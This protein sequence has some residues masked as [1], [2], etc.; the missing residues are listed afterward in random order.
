[1]T[2]DDNVYSLNKLLQ[3]IRD[4]FAQII[5]LLAIIGITVGLLFQY[6]LNDIHS[7]QLAFSIVALGGGAPL[8]LVLFMRLLKGRFGSDLLAGISIITSLILGEYLAGALV[9]LMLSGGESLE[10]LALTNASS[11][12]K[13]LA[14]RLPIYAHRKTE[15][16]YT[17]IEANEIKV[18]D[19]LLLFP[20][21]TCPVDGIVVSGHS[22]MDESY[23]TGEPYLISKTLGSEVISGSLNGE[24][25]LTI[26]ATRTPNTS[27]YAQ[28]VDVM[29]KAEEDRPSL[30]RIGDTLGSWY[31]PLALLIAIAAWIYSGESVRFLSVLVVATPCPLLIA[32]PICIVGGISLCARRGIVIRDPAIMEQIS[33]TTIVILDKTG[34]LTLGIPKITEII[35]NPPYMKS[36]IL[37]YA[38]SIERYSKHPLA[39]AVV[40]AQNKQDIELQTVDTVCEKPGEGLVGY[41]KDKRINITSRRKYGEDKMKNFPS[42][43]GLECVVLVNEALAGIIQFHDAP[44]KDS[45][46][47]ITHLKSKHLVKRVLLVSGDRESEVKYLADLVGVDEIFSGQSPQQKVEIVKKLSLNNK[48]LF[49]GD[50]INDAPA[51]AVAHAG[52]SMGHT[53]DVTIQAAGAVI[54]ESSLRRLDELFHISARMRYIALQSA[55]GGMALSMLGMWLGFFGLITPVIGAIGQEVIDVFAILN[56]LRSVVKPKTL[57]DI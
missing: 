7:S 14:S 47:F 23:L 29:R 9:V 56:A 21:E 3:K 24:G 39:S 8:I 12:L 25:V 53:N 52:V 20:H 45:R 35:A 5:A 30:R 50:G 54:L 40:L 57:S 46:E 1:M 44:R 22:S 6:L 48:T 19:H 2:K 11:A 4:N 43:S 38:A 27:R 37:K 42:S 15:T 17:D 51:L 55:I 36:D 49:V 34:T 28:I 41:I 13:A 18:E 10:H 32:I 31:T 16:G 33:K 26:Q